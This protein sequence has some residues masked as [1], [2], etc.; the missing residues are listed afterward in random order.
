MMR[1]RLAVGALVAGLPW[2]AGCGGSSPS[3]R[4][5]VATPDPTALVAGTTL[6]VASG[7]TGQAVAGAKVVI[8]ARTYEADAG[9]QVTLAERAPFG[10]LVDVTAPGF[11]DRQT[12]IRRDAST[13]LVLWPRRTPSGIDETYTMVLVYTSGAVESTTRGSSPLRRLRLGTTQVVVVPSVEIQQDGQAREAHETAAATL[14][15]AAAG[16]VL[17]A[18]AAT[19]PQTGVVFDARIDPKED[20]CASDRRVLAFTS[21]TI[22]SGEIIG[23]ELVFCR[24][25]SARTSTVTHELGHT[26]GLQHSPDERDLMSAVYQPGFSRTTP[27]PAETLTMGLM[28]ERRGGNRFPDNDRDLP[29]SGTGRVTIV[30][31]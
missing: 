2:L 30:C 25:E 17:Y 13:R 31:R 4:T 11:L 16:R 19:K 3:T 10:S 7:E 22:Q 14:N 23:G 18:V 12:L 20:L 8:A 26:Y 27:S 5:P 15:A 21:L 6:S 24:V 9:G 28:M 29:A 1:S